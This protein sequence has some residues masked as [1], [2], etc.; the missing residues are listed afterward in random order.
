MLLL[1]RQLNG[2][3]KLQKRNDQ[4]VMCR[5]CGGIYGDP[6]SDVSIIDN[7]FTV[8][9][10]G[11]SAWRWS[12][13]YYFTY[14]LPLKDWF[15]STESESTYWNGDPDGSFNSITIP[16]RESGTISFEKYLRY[17]V[18]E[19]KLTNWKVNVAKAYFYD[20]AAINSK[21][22]KTYLIKGDAI[23]SYRE[24]TNFILVEYTNAK[25]KTTRGFIRKK[26]LIRQ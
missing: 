5:E 20:T 1:I 7:S 12:D 11:G 14:N 23:D 6:F 17:S 2:K 3:L 16:A 13:A 25:E 9:F 18:E 22:L 19:A 21:P 8:H 15:I 10:Y 24:T 4:I 26:D